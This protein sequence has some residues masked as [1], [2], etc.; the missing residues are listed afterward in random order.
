MNLCTSQVQVHINTE[1]FL[2]SINIIE[3]FRGLI[4]GVYDLIKELA[5]RKNISVAHLERTLELSNG[6]ISKWNTSNPN[7]EPLLKV[8]NYF[9][10]STDYLLGRTNNP[11]MVNEEPTLLAAHIDD[12]LSD[13]EMQEVLQYI[14]FL[15]SKH[16]K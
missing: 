6:S 15:R 9:G 1:L 8:A 7:S 12:D 3:L 14:E 16:K 10:V 4:M 5:A 13:E 11:K 2:L